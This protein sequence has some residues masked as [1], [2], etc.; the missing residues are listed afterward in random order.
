MSE[1]QTAPRRNPPFHAEHVGSLL[2]PESL[3]RARERLLGPH[4]ADRNLG[5][6]HNQQLR[7]LE[8]QAIRDAVALQ[9]AVGLSVATDGEFRRRTWWTDFV[10]GFEGVVENTGVEAPVVMVDKVG[11][12]RAIPSVRIEGKIRW[13][14]PIMREAFAFLRS[15]TRATPKLTVPAPMDLHY[16][17]GARAGID[18][19][20]YPDLD[21]FLEDLAIAYQR[22][23]ADLADAGCRYLQLDDVTFAFLCDPKRRAEV[24][25]W[26]YEPTQLV[27]RYIKLFN[28]AVAKRPRDLTIGLH[29]CRGNASSHWG[30]EGGYDFVA[31]TLFQQLDVDAFFLEY[32]TPRAGSFEP[33]RFVPKNKVVVLGLLT[34]KDPALEPSEDIKRRIAEASKFIALEQLS[35]SPQCGFASNYIGNP[36]TVDDE[37]RKL[38]LIVDIATEIW[39]TA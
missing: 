1:Q 17:V 7:A 3:R 4:E 15:V 35:L 28:Q 33:L 38:G 39:G 31:P 13:T 2:R 34:S 36:V 32:D 6:H 19:A 27:D 16:F 26:G 23:I 9:E 22:E 10:L 24:Q 30:A 37:R 20:A 29:I 11:H 25:G 21:A 5:P 8:D 14:K 18:K 12:R